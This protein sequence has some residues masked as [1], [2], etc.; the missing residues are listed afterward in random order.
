[1]QIEKWIAVRNFEEVYK[2]FREQYGLT[3][4]SSFF[5]WSLQIISYFA[6]IIHTAFSIKYQLSNTD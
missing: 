4:D 5:S 2:N 3:L 6:V 1:M